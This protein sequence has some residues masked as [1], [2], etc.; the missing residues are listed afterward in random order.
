[1]RLVTTDRDAAL[2]AGGSPRDDAGAVGRHAAEVELPARLLNAG[3]VF[4]QPS[5]V[6]PDVRVAAVGP[7]MKLAVCDAAAFTRRLAAPGR[8]GAVA[9][10]LPWTRVSL[11]A[12]VAEPA[13]PPLRAGR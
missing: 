6:I 7:K 1:M 4:V 10:P 11:P 9:L 12:A 3:A 2:A 13:A 8:Y 5:L